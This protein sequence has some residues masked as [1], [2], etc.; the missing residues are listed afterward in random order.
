MPV[1]RKKEPIAILCADL[2]LSLKRPACRLD[3]DWMETQADY[4]RQLRELQVVGDK[5]DVIPVL[6][7]GDIFDR[8]NPPPELIRFA[9]EHLPD[10]M[11]CVPGQHDLPNHRM[12]EMKR[13]AYGVLVQARKIVDLSGL[14]LY[15]WK[16]PTG[17]IV[18]GFGWGVE[19]EPRSNF[20]EKEKNTLFVALIHRFIWMFETGYPGAPES[21]HVWNTTDC[22]NGYDVAVFGDNHIAFTCKLNGT[23][24]WNC[25]G[26]I[27]RRSD[28]NL[29]RPRVGIL[30][31]DGSV[32]EH[33]LKTGRDKFLPKTEVPEEVEQDMRRFLEE[34]EKLGEHGL[35]FR[36]AVRRH[37]ENKENGISAPVRNLLL[38]FLQD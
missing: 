13:S 25:G 27:R 4:L 35:D 29:R 33:R 3:V 10:G 16:L 2:H 28:E 19:I 32:E 7:A 17:P 21:Q 30:F 36:A 11:I 1:M 37:A 15:E 9:L 12:D 38:S 26:F 5:K 20:Y 23:L 24:I 14:P 34:L 18:K 22:L 31:D 6:C 8:W